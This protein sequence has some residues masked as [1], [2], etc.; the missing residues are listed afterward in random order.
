MLERCDE[1]CDAPH[2][3]PPSNPGGGCSGFSLIELV[4]VLAVVGIITLWA[5]PSYAERVRATHRIEAQGGL[6]EA[7]QWLERHYT[8]HGRYPQVVQDAQGAHEGGLPVALRAVPQQPGTPPRYHLVF[9]ELT[10]HAYLLAAQPVGSMQHDACGAFTLDHRGV[11]SQRDWQPGRC[12]SG[13]A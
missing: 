12:R 8:L 13:W 11:R 2:A 5:Y 6:V 9:L 3:C 7:A 10:A 4:V 1:Q